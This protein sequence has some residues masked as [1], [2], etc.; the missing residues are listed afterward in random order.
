MY[1]ALCTAFKKTAARAAS[2]NP[3][4]RFLILFLT[5]SSI[6]FA[7]IHV[8]IKLYTTM[9]N[10]KMETAIV[11]VSQGSVCL[12]L[13]NYIV[14]MAKRIHSSCPMA[15]VLRHQSRRWHPT[16]PS[17]CVTPRTVL[18]TTTPSS[19]WDLSSTKSGLCD[20]FVPIVDRNFYF[21]VLLII[22]LGRHI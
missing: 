4:I 6:T 15:A 19:K 21:K 20:F 13:K 18:S 12:C 8:N 11:I 9:K 22:V 5:S 2:L 3:S 17:R 10:K 14:M 1:C 7:R 16:A